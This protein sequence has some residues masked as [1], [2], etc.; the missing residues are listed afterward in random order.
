M[1]DIGDTTR[2]C[3]CGDA[4]ATAAS[5]IPFGDDGEAACSTECWNEHERLDCPFAQGFNYRSKP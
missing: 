4:L 1:T 3:N 5:C 2:C